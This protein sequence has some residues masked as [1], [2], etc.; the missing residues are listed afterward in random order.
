MSHSGLD[1]FSDIALKVL[2]PVGSVLIISFVMLFIILSYRYFRGCHFRSGRKN[3]RGKNSAIVKASEDIQLLDKLNVVNR[4]PSYFGTN[5]EGY[6]KR[7][8]IN[9][10]P[11]DNVRLQEVVGEG[12]FGQVYKGMS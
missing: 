4:N 6:G 10:I 8:V 9:D 11:V 5:A 2:L 12:A 1:T 7:W 3:K